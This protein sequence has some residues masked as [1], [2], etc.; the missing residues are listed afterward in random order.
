[1]AN[2]SMMSI[3]PFLQS[4]W[5]AVEQAQ[6]RLL[7]SENLLISVSACMWREEIHPLQDEE[8]ATSD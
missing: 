3:D 2:V 1:M 4:F 7:S 8:A 6:T 5:W